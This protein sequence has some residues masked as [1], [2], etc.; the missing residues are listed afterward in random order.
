MFLS[1]WRL[2]KAFIWR[3]D[4]RVPADPALHEISM[5]A[6]LPASKL[7][8]PAAQPEAQPPTTPP[9]SPET[10]QAT[11]LP[12]VAAPAP[13]APTNHRLAARLASVRKLNKPRKAA[14]S[15]HR[16]APAGKPIPRAASRVVAKKKAK[17]PQAWVAA[18]RLRK[19]SRPM[20]QVIAFPAPAVQRS[21]KPLR[22]AA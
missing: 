15:R 19:P 6:V 13:R 10:A 7:A 16:I 14:R 8:S 1:V 3:Q 11:T 2:V 18:G 20:A 9:A 22:K 5:Q 4:G 12:D 21:V 17:R